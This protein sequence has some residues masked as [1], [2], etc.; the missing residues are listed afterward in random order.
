MRMVTFEYSFSEEFYAELWQRSFDTRKGARAWARVRVILA[1]FHLTVL[2]FLIYYQMDT[3]AVY[4]A[5]FLLLLVVSQ[6]KD[7]RPIMQRFRKS[8][9]C[10]DRYKVQLSADGFSS[11]SSKSNQH[12]K[13]AA[14]TEAI[15]AADGFLLFH[16]DS[17]VNWL[18]FRALTEGSIEEA[19]VLIRANVP[20]YR[21]A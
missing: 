8:P 17:F 1:I 9:Y 19:A 7:M 14:F 18:P 6:R 3:L 16:G 2:G 15:R 10:D 12:L 13:W 21:Q 5:V 4:V 20:K 11:V